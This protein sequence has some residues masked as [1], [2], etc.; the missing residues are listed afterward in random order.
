MKVDADGTALYGTRG[1]L[2]DRAR[3]SLYPT[4]FAELANSLE[5]RTTVCE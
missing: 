4:T 2:I 3:G 1:Q 5:I